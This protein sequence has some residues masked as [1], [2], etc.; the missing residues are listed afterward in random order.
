MK[1]T[2]AMYFGTNYNISYASILYLTPN[3]D[4]LPFVGFV[5]YAECPLYPK[6]AVFRKYLPRVMPTPLRYETQTTV[7]SEIKPTP[8]VLSYF[9][10]YLS[11]A[12]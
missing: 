8:E 12:D 9:G 1:Y 4:E 2:A 11:L 6:I 7:T 10:Y 3:G 5:S